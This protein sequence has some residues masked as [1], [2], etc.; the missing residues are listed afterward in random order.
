MTPCSIRGVLYGGSLPD[1]CFP[2]SESRNDHLL[3]AHGRPAHDSA[4][5]AIRSTAYRLWQSKRCIW[6]RIDV[7][8]TSL[9]TSFPLVF[10]FCFQSL[11]ALLKS[12][13]VNFHFILLSSSW[14]FTHLTNRS[15][16][17]SSRR[18]ALLTR[19]WN[20]FSSLPFTALLNVTVFLREKSPTEAISLLMK[21]KASCSPIGGK[22]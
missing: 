16:F 14:V 12:R 22:S 9:N 13:S 1:R 15:F 8:T 10:P 3:S 2:I 5:A 17:S 18:A 11:M 7:W 6:M 21:R 19:L 20:S 4:E